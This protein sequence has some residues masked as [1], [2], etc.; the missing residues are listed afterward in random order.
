MRIMVDSL[1]LWTGFGMDALAQGVR[2]GLVAGQVGQHAFDALGVAA[3]A[4]APCAVKVGIHPRPLDTQFVAQCVDSVDAVGIGRHVGTRGG[5]GFGGFFRGIRHGGGRWFLRRRGVDGNVVYRRWPALQHPGC[6]IGHAQGG[7]VVLLREQGGDVHWRLQF[8]DPVRSAYWL[9]GLG[10]QV[11]YLAQLLGQVKRRALSVQ[12]AGE[13][14]ATHE[15]NGLEAFDGARQGVEAV[16]VQFERVERADARDVEN[17]APRQVALAV[18]K[19]RA[20]FRLAQAAVVGARLGAAAAEGAHGAL[21]ARVDPGRRE[22]HAAARL[23]IG[24]ILAPVAFLV[25]RPAGQFVWH[26]ALPGVGREDDRESVQAHLAVALVFAIGQQDLAS[27]FRVG[28]V[29]WTHGEPGHVLGR[30]RRL[31]VGEAFGDLTLDLLER[32]LLGQ[33]ILVQ[34]AD[35]GIASGGLGEHLDTGADLPCGGDAWGRA[36]ENRRWGR[37]RSENGSQWLV[38][39]CSCRVEWGLQSCSHPASPVQVVMPHPA[40]YRRAKAGP[41]VVGAWAA[42]ASQADTVV[43]SAPAPAV[44]GG[45]MHA[46]DQQV[47]PRRRRMCRNRHRQ[48]LLAQ[49]DGA[50]LDTC[51]KQALCHAHCLPQRQ[52]KQALDG[53]AK[54]NHRLAVPRP[55]APFA[56]GAAMPAHVL[57]HSDQQRAA[58]LQRG[59]IV[60]PVDRAVLRFYCRA[61]ADSYL[62]A[63]PDAGGH[64]CNKAV[65]KCFRR[66]HFSECFQLQKLCFTLLR[67]KLAL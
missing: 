55:A 21:A 47:Q 58:R 46:V 17:E 9:A 24:R 15:G 56:A 31:H 4:R 18:L 6:G 49:A 13:A 8:D 7:L 11:G 5:G 59:V 10:I 28:E 36:A 34:G 62:Q 33:A 51:L 19:F 65:R 30:E 29:A 27:E 45:D 20:V 43:T 39:A 37:C 61:H 60:L 26:D 48:M 32:G 54:L 44:V 66:D 67:G 25:A 53:Q 50:E 16:G 23:A 64:L 3:P 41:S 57:V 22:H 38:H 35:R 12:E 2:I 1:L 14:P 40:C 52:V 42:F 63:S